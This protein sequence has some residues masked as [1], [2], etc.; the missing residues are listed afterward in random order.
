MND[1]NNSIN[2]KDNELLIS[3]EVIKMSINEILIVAPIGNQKFITDDKI[4]RLKIQ[5]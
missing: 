5:G 2:Q 3:Q 1:L 4:T